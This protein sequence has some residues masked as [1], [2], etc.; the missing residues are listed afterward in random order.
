MSSPTWRAGGIS[1]GARLP[2]ALEVHAGVRSDGVLPS[3]LR[4][5]SRRESVRRQAAF[6]VTPNGAVRSKSRPSSGR[7]GSVPDV[8]Y[9]PAQPTL[10]LRGLRL[11]T[12]RAERMIDLSGHPEPVQ[13]R[14]ELARHGDHRAL[15]RPLAPLA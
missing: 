3:K 14:R 10:G 6:A 11:L 9:L 7:R 5:H 8:S 1:I 13:E 15:L 4:A 2:S 12:R